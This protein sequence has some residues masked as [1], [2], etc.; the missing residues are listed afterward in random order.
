MRHVILIGDSIRMAYQD[1]VRRLLTG[2]CEVWAPA[3]NG[4]TSANVLAHLDAWVLARRADL[5]HLNCG[6]HD[7][8]RAR[9]GGAL[10]VPLAAY[11]EN[12]EALFGRLLDAGRRLLW[13]STTPVNHA[14]HRDHKPFDRFEEDVLAYNRAAAGIAA[15][16]GVPV[17]DLYGV[18]MVAGRDR[19][20]APDGVHFTDEGSE[21]LARAVA[22]A[23]RAAL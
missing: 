1:G 23:V 20:L 2:E 17:D 7:L 22:A 10:N 6:L 19:L 5:V 11:R 13:A 15:R 9:P 18:V 8:R 14:W 4:G 16:A 3:E 12:L 21:V